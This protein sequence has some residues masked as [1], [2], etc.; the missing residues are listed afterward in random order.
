VCV[1]VEQRLPGFDTLLQMYAST[2]DRLSP[3]QVRG[4]LA[5]IQ[6]SGALAA[7]RRVLDDMRAAILSHADLLQIS[8]FAQIMKKL[9]VAV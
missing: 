5:V 7:T 1:M 8:A 4:A 6:S 3:E 9:D 2:P